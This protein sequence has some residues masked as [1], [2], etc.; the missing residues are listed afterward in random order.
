MNPE[1]FVNSAESVVNTA[2]NLFIKD[3]AL[4]TAATEL[5]AA[6]R[7]L[8]HTQLNCSTALVNLW[9]QELGKVQNPFVV[10]DKK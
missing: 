8:A 4:N 10:G 1:F 9:M 7:A 6:S 5:V 3:E 2:I